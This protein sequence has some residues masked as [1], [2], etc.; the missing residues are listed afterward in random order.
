MEEFDDIEQQIR[1]IIA[2]TLQIDEGLIHK[3][4]TIGELGGDSLM[5]LMLI[6]SLETQFNIT[7]SDDDALKINSFDSAAAVVKKLM[8]A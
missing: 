7:I 5:A 2:E 8:N 3:D 6:T 4:S 1:K